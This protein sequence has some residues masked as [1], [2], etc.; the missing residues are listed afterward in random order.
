M[1]DLTYYVGTS[2]DGFA[3]GPQ[4]EIDFYPVSDDHLAQM[5]ET[6][7]EVLPTHVRAHLG[8]DAPNRRF[9]TVIQGRRSYQIALDVGITSPYAH[10]H[11]YVA[12][13]TVTSSDPAVTVVAD[14]AAA[15]RELK[16]GDG[17]GIWLAG[18]GTL[19]GALADE[20]DRLVVKV[21]PVLAGAGRP[22][23]T[24]GFAP[25]PFRLTEQSAPFD[26]GVTILTYER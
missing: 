16:S 25:R 18:G 5:V 10:L 22:V 9:D 17:L 6:C 11:Q 2:I 14:P 8:V 24:A 3:A 21:Y 4:D 13:T 23:F 15:V 1:R 12:S 20:I 19:A 26:S 7:P